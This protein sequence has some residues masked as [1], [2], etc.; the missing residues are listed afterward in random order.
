M[1]EKKAIQKDTTI[2]EIVVSFPELVRP[3]MEHGI[4]CIACGEPVWGTVEENA[5]EKGIT[6]LDEIIDS[7]NEKIKKK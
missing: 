7:L 5:K 6:N 2:E 1:S 4:K 3:L